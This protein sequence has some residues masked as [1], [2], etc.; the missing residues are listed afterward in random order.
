MPSALSFFTADKCMSVIIIM[1]IIIAE[2]AV[3]NVAGYLVEERR[4]RPVITASPRGQKKPD[5]R[6]HAQITDL[7]A[8]RVN[9]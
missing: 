7:N 5:G 1:I 9:Q 4:R 8:V 3:F 6:H 2:M